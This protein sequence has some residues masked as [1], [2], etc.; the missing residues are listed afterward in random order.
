[1][2]NN[3][4]G[5]RLPSSSQQSRK[6]SAWGVIVGITLPGVFLSA[7]VQAAKF[8]ANSLADPPARDAKPGDLFS[9]PF[10]NHRLSL[11]HRQWAS[12]TIIDGNKSIRPNSGVLSIGLTL[13]SEITVSISRVT[14]RNGSAR[15]DGGDLC[16]GL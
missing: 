6:N 7:S 5:Q 14:I 2:T 12:V 10:Y 11:P 8:K 1:M 13:N 15:E 9:A 4:R 3:W 16:A